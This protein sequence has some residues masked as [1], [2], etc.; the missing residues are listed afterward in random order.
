MDDTK[1]FLN[2]I[3]FCTV[4]GMDGELHQ[5][6]CS[7]QRGTLES[8]LVTARQVRV[9]GAVDADNV[10]IH[11]R[12]IETMAWSHLAAGRFVDFGAMA[13]LWTVMNERRGI[14]KPSPFQVLVHIASDFANG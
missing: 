2:G 14:N 12:S 13:G 8:D 10:L 7:T 4:C 1:R 11:L 3:G 5:P 6:W 9:V